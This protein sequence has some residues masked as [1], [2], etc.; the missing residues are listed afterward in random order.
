MS[1]EGI[2]FA[3]GRPPQHA[4]PTLDSSS[5]LYWQNRFGKT[6][7]EFDGKGKVSSIR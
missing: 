6:A 3:M 4:N 1:K 2:L 7:I 5:W